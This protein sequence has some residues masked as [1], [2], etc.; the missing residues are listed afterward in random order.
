MKLRIVMYT[1]NSNC[2]YFRVQ[3]KSLLFWSDIGGLHNSLEGAQEFAKRIL[4]FKEEII[5]AYETGA[6]EKK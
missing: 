2:I 5:T 1:G 3:K 4:D 6:E